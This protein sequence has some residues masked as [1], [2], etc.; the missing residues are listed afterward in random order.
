M[1]LI[2]CKIENFGKLKDVSF[3]FSEGANVICHRNGWGKSTLAAFIRVMFFGFENANKQDALVNERKRF[4]PWQGGVYGGSITFETDARQYVMRRVFGK[5]E[6]DDEFEL[7]EVSTNLPSDD[8]TANIGEELFAIDRASFV[9]TVFISQQD[10][11]TNSTDSIHAKLGNLVQNTDDLNSFQSVYDHLKD[12]T[13]KMVPTRK[14]GS[15]NKEKTA[16]AKM[17]NDLRKA[18][19]IKKSIHEVEVLRKKQ[20]E[21][22][23]RLEEEI[24]AWQEKQSKVSEN[25]D[26]TV[27]KKE[28]AALQRA[29]EQADET[30]RSCRRAFP[31]E[32]HI[33]TPDQVSQW[34]E[35]ERQCE[36]YHD[37]MLENQMSPEEMRSYESIKALLKGQIPTA[38]NM[39]ELEQ[40]QKEY[41]QL[42]LQLAAGRLTPVEEQEWEALRGRYPQGVPTEE[43]TQR[44]RDTWD[45][46]QRRKEGITSKKAMRETLL[47]M[48]ARQNKPSA[49]PALLLV[50]CAFVFG[51]A[52]GVFVQLAVGI[53]VLVAFLIM[54]VFLFAKNRKIQEKPKQD[55]S[56]RQ[57]EQEIVEDEEMIQQGIEN[58]LTFVKVYAPS[59]PMEQI[60]LELGVL[61]TDA[62]RYRALAARKGSVDKNE[63]STRYGVL[64]QSL[65]DFMKL[66]YEEDIP[67]EQWASRLS[68]LKEQVRN[69][70]RWQPKTEAYMAA[71]EQYQKTRHLLE[72]ELNA[73]QFEPEKPL[74]LLLQD[75]RE[76]VIQYVQAKEACDRAAGQKDVFEETNDLAKLQGAT[77]VNEED[78]LH[79]IHIRLEQCLERKERVQRDI[80]AY[81]D[82]LQSLQ[83]QLDELMALQVEWEER[84]EIYQEGKKKYNLLIKTMELLQRAKDNLTAR[85]MGPVQS[86]FEKYYAMISGEEPDNYQFDASANLTVNELGMSREIRFL[87]EGSKDLAGICTRMALVDAMYEEEKPFVI[88]DDPFVNLDRDKTEK[89]LEFLQSISKEYQVLY[90]TCHESRSHE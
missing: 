86:G 37:A 90:F 13:N 24:H 32:R 27:K 84:K 42:K 72:K 30:C 59:S 76:Q 15:L 5:K 18:E 56:L 43:Q 58:V 66:Y 14:T 33:P 25:L 61:L 8:F 60:R 39:E 34:Q 65:S 44:M 50:I 82:Q 12:K 81:D 80:A 21:N 47:S 11:E 46:V 85:Y 28:Y 10:C 73:Y 55:D 74:S 9:R 36:Q 23:Q 2:Q 45:E 71:E 77:D 67:E 51:A 16:I 79:E 52:V 22:R 40:A 63:Q 1:K 75:I 7:R 49:L 87:S 6:K 78:S 4:F 62:G 83:E 69:Y 70:I 54:A 53:V 29:Y 41:D 17:E 3:D 48:S 64:K 38:E 57:L 88:L 68:A 35:M 26:L 20:A 31:D 19:S 89:A